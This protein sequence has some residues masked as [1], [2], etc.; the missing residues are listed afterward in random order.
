MKAVPYFGDNAN[1][2]LT[3]RF[4]CSYSPCQ[5]QRVNRG[6]CSQKSDD[7][8]FPGYHDEEL[9]IG[10]DVELYID[11]DEELYI[12]HGEYIGMVL[13]IDHV[14]FVDMVVFTERKETARGPETITVKGPFTRFSKDVTTRMYVTPASR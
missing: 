1:S 8:L 9:Y 14:A 5:S 11:H 7:L 4:M 12:D 2:F 3:E 10:H 6:T 13:F